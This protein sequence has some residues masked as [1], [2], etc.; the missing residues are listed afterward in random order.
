MQLY[1]E[2]KI[3]YQ[4]TITKEEGKKKEISLSAVSCMPVCSKLHQPQKFNKV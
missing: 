4:P 3:V 2:K 1:L